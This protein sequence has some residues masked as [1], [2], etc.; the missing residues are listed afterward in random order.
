MLCW[1]LM[2]VVTVFEEELQRRQQVA[3]WYTQAFAG[4]LDTLPYI[5]PENFSAYAQY[6]IQVE[7]RDSMRV[8]MQEQGIPTAV[9]YPKVLYQQPVIAAGLTEPVHC[10]HAERAAARV[11]SLP[12][13]PYLEKTTVEKIAETVLSLNAKNLTSDAELVVTNS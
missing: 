3:E 13:D 1:V 9:H 8:K 2:V 6:S 10:P 7:N 11:I 5:A 4:R 12:F